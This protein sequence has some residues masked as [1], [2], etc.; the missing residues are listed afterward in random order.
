M[1]DLMISP[2]TTPVEQKLQF[3]L[4]SQ[5]DWWVYAI[6][7]HTSNDDNGNLFLSWGDGHFH[8]SK[9]TSPRI[10]TAAHDHN[11]PIRKIMKGIQSLVSDNPNDK[12]NNNMEQITTNGDLNDAEWFYVMSLT[13]THPIADHHRG[14]S[15]SLLG[16]AFTS[17]SS[18][19]LNRRKNEHQFYN[20][21]RAKEAFVHGIETLVCIPTSYGV[22]EMGSYDTITENWGL[23]Q[24]AKSLFSSADL[25][26][27]SHPKQPN[28]IQLFDDHNISFA[29]IGIIAGVQE[30]DNSTPAQRHKRKRSES[31]K[32]NNDIS[33]VKF[34]SSYVDSEHSDS[35]FPMG[36]PSNIA[37]LEKR[38]T[39]KRGR[40]PELGRETPSNHVEAE[41]QRREKLN[42]RFYALRAA[43]P[44]VSRMDKAS[45]LSDAVSYIN[46]LKAKI[47][48]LESKVERESSKKVKLEMADAVDNQSTTT[49]TVDQTRPNGN[50][51]SSL[52]VEVKIIGADAMVRVQSENTSHPGARLMGALRDLELRV[53]HASMSCVDDLMLQDVVVK[54]PQRLRSEESL[55]S[56]I[57]ARLDQ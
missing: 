35:D 19:W 30:E 54:I 27:L 4:Q 16:K 36:T 21:E 11:Y 46:E 28:P 5:H 39:K 8:G 50:G 49:S 40:K 26:A 29:D 38:P 6:F 56:A 42:H 53:H 44:N 32:D 55:K 48:D 31:T 25:L 47:E 41:R 10:T 43:V 15:S 33:G 17:G 34:G 12:D 23:L 51:S 20:C 52:E 3:L 1:E 7:W 13:R 9:D 2:T 45:L 14:S 57:L 37:Q 18:I 24:K 22:I